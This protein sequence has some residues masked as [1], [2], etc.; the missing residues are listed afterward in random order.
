MPSPT[1]TRPLRVA[2]VGNPNCGK[3]TV[4]NALTGLSQKVGNY[5]GVTVERRVGTRKRP[6]G[7]ILEI[8]DIPGTYSLGIRSPDE[9]VAVNL[10][11]G[12]LPGERS[13]DV[14]VN[15]VDASNLARN[16]FLTS[17]LLELDRP[18]VVVLNMM[19]V[20]RRRGLVP[21]ARAM[22]EALGVP[23]IPLENHGS[24]AMD[25]VAAAIEQVAER[26]PP[27]PVVP[28]EGVLSRYVAELENSSRE[29]IPRAAALLA[30]EGRE[31]IDGLDAGRL[32]QV[33]G[34]LEREDPSWWKREAGA[35]YRW[36]DAHLS[37]FLGGSCEGTAPPDT[38][39]ARADRILLH[40]FFGPLIFLGVMAFVFQ[41][42]F[43]WASVPS[44]LLESGFN[45]L[46]GLVGR[47]IGPGMFHDF[48]LGG[49]L[50]GVLN[51]LV[52][53]PQIVILFL[54]IG[55]LEDSGYMARGVF[56]MDRIMRRFGLHGRAFVPLMSS[57]ACA[58]PGIMSTRTIGNPVTRLTTILVA[59]LMSCSARLPVYTLV[60]AAFFGSGK[61]LGVMSTGGLVL[62]VLYALGIA[63]AA[64]MSL[65]F[66][67]FLVKGDPPALLMELPPYRMPRAG[68]VLRQ[69]WI[70]SLLFVKKVWTII[71]VVTATLWFL[72]TF[73][74][75]DSRVAVADTQIEAIDNALADGVAPSVRE[76]LLNSKR[77]I[78]N[79]LRSAQ[80]EQSFAGVVG[81]T[82]EPVIRP[83]GFDWRLGIGLLASF[84]AREVLV[85]TMAQ[86]FAVGVD[87]D[88]VASLATRIRT[89]KD[90][91]TGRL[92]YTPLTGMS[93]AV[94][95]VLAC[96]CMSTL[97]IVRR[98][99]GT[100]RWP[101]FLFGYMTILAW[102][103]SFL[104]Y[105][106]G[107]LWMA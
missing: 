97:A 92:L 77:D 25:A 100:W 70:Q 32:E 96:Q 91:E 63:A 87:D 89:A 6:G 4:F 61:V 35:R 49:V 67:R 45:A 65:L 42:I 22:A 84:A 37:C 85:S 99:T 94:F 88:D 34:A 52:F 21:D 51:V 105:Q 64:L 78:R 40:R 57:F 10:L 43:T 86:V 44:D 24:M 18:V 106:L 28:V 104:T 73:P 81:K 95:F 50:S 29:T 2:L 80:L 47:W 68:A 74:R 107:S 12:R 36:I 98:E 55:F 90:P 27:R 83:L 30:L 11:M 16:L 62:L 71:L 46:S 17:Q 76:R 7:D 33:R 66:R 48:V 3:T 59:P 31:T 1:R 101:A 23:V 82:I 54:F 26:P 41:G 38:V 79:Q 13:P 102:V 56:I 69:T 103:A 19:D 14:I 5:P 60:I 72:Q 93:L 39:T 75:D 8:V 9:A 15:V 20:A 58:V 53:L